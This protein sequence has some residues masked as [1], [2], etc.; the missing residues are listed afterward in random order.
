[1]NAAT[2]S[3]Y[4]PFSWMGYVPPSAQ[5]LHWITQGY[6]LPNGYVR[7]HA[8]NL[9][10]DMGNPS[11]KQFYDQLQKTQREPVHSVVLQADR[12]PTNADEPAPLSAST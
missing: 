9:T 10:L 11:D 3:F 6:L 8:R 1:M 5:R 2:A 12:Y 4:N 7:E